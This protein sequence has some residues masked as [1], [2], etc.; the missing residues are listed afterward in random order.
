MAKIAEVQEVTR[1]LLKPYERNAKVHGAEQVEKI[2]RSIR[3]FGFLSPCLIDRDYNIIA[4]H[5]RV[6]AAEK[7]GLET[8]PCVFIEGLTEEQRKAYI[9]ADNRLTEL[10]DWDRDLVSEE[11]EALAGSGFDVSL[12]GFDWDSVSKIDPIE[13]DYDPEDPDLIIEARAKRGDVFQLGEHRLMCGDS[14]NQQDMNRLFDG[15]GG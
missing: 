9:L 1:T 3:E 8:V 4:G 5:G 14:A 7:I 11:L 12:T 15:G 2:A 10:G 13:D 6:M